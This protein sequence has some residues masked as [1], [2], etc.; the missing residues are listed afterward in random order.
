MTAIPIT[1]PCLG[2][3]EA[4]AA[5][6]AIA[7]GWLSQGPRVQEFERVL[8]EFVGVTEAIATTN[9]TTALHLA[10][11]AA[12]VRP[13]DQVI[14]PSFT[15]IATANAILYAG[16]EPVF[17]DIEPRTLNIDPECVE[18]AITPRTRAIVPVDQIGLAADILAILE[19]AR[20]HGLRVVEDAAPSLGA[21]VGPARVGSLSDFTCFSFHPRKSI[22]TGEG[23]M[24]TTNKPDAAARLRRLRSHG[25]S[26]SDLARHRSGSIDIEEYAE[27]GFNYRMTDI[28]AAIGIVQMS[29]LETILIERRRLARRYTSMLAGVD[30]VEPP[31][32]PPGR[33]HTYQSYCIRVDARARPRVMIDLAAAGIAS[34]RGV[35]AVHLEPFYRASQPTV[36][37]PHTERATAETLLLPLYV[38][39]TESDQDRVVETLARSLRSAV[40]TTSTMSSRWASVSSG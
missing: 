30:G 5:G 32:E 4:Q 40:T 27:L 12:G 24:I 17:V 26:T 33:P 16:A 23:G 11:L 39:M 35:M 31:G 8:A 19:I 29:R 34:R 21:T 37:L 9:C 25:A 3:E 6:E 10:L 28:Q 20:R 22:T 7:S 1:R 14:C 2:P 18:A 36:A 15:F 13:G 38:G